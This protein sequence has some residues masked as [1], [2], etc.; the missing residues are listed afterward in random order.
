MKMNSEELKMATCISENNCYQRN[1]PYYRTLTLKFQCWLYC[2][3]LSSYAGI[4]PDN[5][6]FQGC[7]RTLDS[8][9]LFDNHQTGAIAQKNLFCIY[10]GILENVALDEE[11]NLREFTEA[12][13]KYWIDLSE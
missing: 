9:P 6:C 2:G 8:A 11:E 5:Y 13:E 10:V 3:L 7:P 12:V 4:K 1:R